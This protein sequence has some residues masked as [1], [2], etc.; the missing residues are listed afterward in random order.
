MA[1]GRGYGRV[2]PPRV[3]NEMVSLAKQMALLATLAILALAGAWYR[4]GDFVSLWLTA[5]QRGR[6]EFDRRH[7]GEAADLFADPQ[8]AGVAAY[9]AGRYIEA[10]ESFGRV[11]S[12]VGM[13]NRGNALLKGREYHSAI[14]SYEQA[15]V[16]DPNLKVAH[17]NLELARRI[18]AYLEEAREQGGNSEIGADD[19]KFDNKSNKGAETVISDRSR[20]EAA[21]AEQW[22]RTVDTRMRD[23]LRT[24][25][26]VEAARRETP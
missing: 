12:A 5:D 10:A 9:E 6:V 2:V 13:F 3:D 22:M 23:Y 18:V 26:M 15:L 25:F 20:L 24:R 17:R 4:A 16:F 11:P 21:S 14:E 19:F 8:W 7:F 1:G